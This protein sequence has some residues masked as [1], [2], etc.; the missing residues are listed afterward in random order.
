[1]VAL[2]VGKQHYS[3]S[4]E[5]IVEIGNLLQS[6]L[7]LQQFLHFRIMY[8]E[9]FCY[10]RITVMFTLTNRITVIFT[11]TKQDYCYVYINYLGL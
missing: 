5:R 3:K 11:L 4:Y 10:N 8:A 7:R 1:M 9:L 2:F 6:C